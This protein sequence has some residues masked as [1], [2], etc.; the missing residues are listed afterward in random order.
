MIV[1][2]RCDG[3]DDAKCTEKI[4]LG[5]LCQLNGR[6]WLQKIKGAKLK[7]QVV[8]VKGALCVSYGVHKGRYR[9]IREQK[10]V[11]VDDAV[12]VASFCNQSVVQRFNDMKAG[13]YKRKLNDAS[14]LCISVVLYLL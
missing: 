9:E 2:L 13:N 11:N 8:E 3:H 5:S 10:E 14:P 1:P 12:S 7:N 6:Q 4:C